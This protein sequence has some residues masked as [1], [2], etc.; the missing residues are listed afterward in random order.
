MG[1]ET[2]LPG[3]EVLT[4]GSVTGAEA[5]PVRSVRRATARRASRR[6]AVAR[7]RKGDMK[8]RIVDFLTQH[9]GSTAGDLARGLNMPPGRVASAV[10]QLVKAGVIGRA[11]RGYRATQTR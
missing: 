11:S 8:A 6:R 5:A 2:R 9:A 3:A 4:E 10:A 1:D 7:D